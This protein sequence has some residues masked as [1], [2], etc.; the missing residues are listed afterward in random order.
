[1]L[2]LGQVDHLQFIVRDTQFEKSSG[3]EVIFIKTIN[4]NINFE[5]STVTVVQGT[6]IVLFVAHIKTL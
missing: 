6:I 4:K 2:R 1:M 3:W 5:G